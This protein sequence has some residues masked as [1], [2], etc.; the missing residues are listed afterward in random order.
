MHPQQQ[1]FLSLQKHSNHFEAS[2]F[3]VDLAVQFLKLIY[4]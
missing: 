3:A 4:K 1:A 2:A